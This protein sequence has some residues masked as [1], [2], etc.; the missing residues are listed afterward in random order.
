M[1]PEIIIQINQRLLIALQSITYIANSGHPRG[2]RCRVHW[3]GGGW[4]VLQRGSQQGVKPGKDSRHLILNWRGAGGRTLT[5]A[6]VL[7]PVAFFTGVHR[8]CNKKV[9]F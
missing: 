3:R 4:S 2:R 5:A 1:P 7:P 8:D 9:V 6:I